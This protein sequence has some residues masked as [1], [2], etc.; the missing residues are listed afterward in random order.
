M[1]W[2][3]VSM[4]FVGIGILSLGVN[5]AA[6]VITFDSIPASWGGHLYNSISDSGFNVINSAQAF[7]ISDGASFC[8]P[9]CPEN[10]T[11]Y[12]ITQW[13]IG[14]GAISV[15]ANN[16][17]SF[18]LT[19][20]QYAEAYVG[21]PYSPDVSVVG[22][23]SDGGI[24]TASFVLDGINDGAGPL[25][26]FQ[27]AMLPTT[28]QNLTSVEFKAAYRQIIS[29]DNIVATPV[30][31]PSS[32]AFLICGFGAVIPLYPLKRR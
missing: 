7:Y 17:S 28:F 12:L 21:L 10:G 14:R 3:S 23:L 27:T 15:S 30:P 32:L 24:V 18:D 31:E 8:I 26:D 1:I 13:E 16:G 9:Q 2:H 22:H 25:I 29:L 5:A 4:I 19:S 11:H 6:A 20:F